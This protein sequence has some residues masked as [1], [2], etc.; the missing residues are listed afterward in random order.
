MFEKVL[1]HRAQGHTAGSMDGGYIASSQEQRQRYCGSQ[2][3]HCLFNLWV[4]TGGNEKSILV[5]PRLALEEIYRGASM[6]SKCKQNFHL[7]QMTLFV[8]A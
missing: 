6:K 4:E 7:G 8:Q 5:Q 1:I 2:L 3:T